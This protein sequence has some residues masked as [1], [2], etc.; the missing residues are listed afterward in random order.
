MHGISGLS[1]GWMYLLLTKMN[2]F[3]SAAVLRLLVLAGTVAPAVPRL[4]IG[5]VSPE[6][7]VSVTAGHGTGNLFRPFGPASVHWTLCKERVWRIPP[8]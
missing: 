1:A 3:R 5:A 4:G 8:A 7:F 6:N 2:A